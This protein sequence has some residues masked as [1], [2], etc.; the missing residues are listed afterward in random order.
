M[1]SG[2]TR[3]G[4]RLH[5]ALAGQPAACARTSTTLA[6]APRHAAHARAGRA[7][8]AGRPARGADRRRRARRGRGDPCCLGAARDALDRA[9]ALAILARCRGLLLAARGDLEGAFADSSARC[10]STPAARI[11]S[12]TPGRCSRSAE[13][14]GVPSSAARP[15]RPSRTRSRASSG[16][17]RRS[18]PSRRAPSSPGSAA[19]R[20]ARRADRGRARIARSSP[21]AARTARSRLRS[22]SP[23]TPSRRHSAVSTASSA[24]GPAPSC[25]HGSA[26]DV[27]AHA[28]PQRPEVS[29][30]RRRR[31]E[32]EP[33]HELQRPRARRRH[34]KANRRRRHGGLAGAGHRRLCGREWSI[35][36][37]R[38]APGLSAQFHN[39]DAAIGSWLR[40]R[41][42]ERCRG[43][44]SSPGCVWRTPRPERWGT[45]TSTRS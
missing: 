17:A 3:L 10:P 15:G 1:S 28:S 8:R 14:N 16:S 27:A 33:V 21:R 20:L 12:T 24:S 4:A 5:R 39:V 2:G 13:P 40:A 45:T 32:R 25:A 35:R 26:A 43:T 29:R 38:R 19:A 7:P 30:F 22:S 18:G 36:A 23:S 44:G 9:W 31:V 11:R 6:R 37:R 34:P 41:L 42:R